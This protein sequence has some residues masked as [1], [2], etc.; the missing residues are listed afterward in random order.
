MKRS[1]VLL[2]ICALLHLGGP[3]A[4]GMSGTSI[5]AW[6]GK[7]ATG[8]ADW[9]EGALALVN[10]PVRTTGWNPW[11][12]EW[13][14]DVN[15]YGFQVTN[16]ADVNGLIQRFAAIK[17][18]NMQVR[19]NPGREARS[20]GFSTVLKDGNEVCVVFCLGSQTQINEWFQRLPEEEPGVRKFGVHYL[21]E[22]PKATPP[23]LT[24]YVANPAI[25]LRLLEIP[26]HIEVVADIRPPSPAVAT[27]SPI[28]KTI[29]DFVVGRKAS[30]APSTQAKEAKP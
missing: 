13:P 9:P 6:P 16:S 23:T 18:T 19:L 3:F 7:P 14:N 12:S 24:L 21:R 30:P 11:F 17:S 8:K 29:E 2:A 27:N 28:V 20:L 10:D 4:S 25:S 22:A 15:H 26:G 1:V 5:V